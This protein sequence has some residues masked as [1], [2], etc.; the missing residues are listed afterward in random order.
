[1]LNDINNPHTLQPHTGCFT[2]I[3]PTEVLDLCVELLQSLPVLLLQELDVPL[4]GSDAGVGVG[5]TGH[6]GSSG[7][8]S[9]RRRDDRERLKLAQRAGPPQTAHSG[10]VWQVAHRWEVITRH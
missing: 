8:S 4:Q 10:P 5:V 3:V 2:F 1:M 9:V 7:R 6:L